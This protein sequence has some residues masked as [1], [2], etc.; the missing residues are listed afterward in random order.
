MGQLDIG[1]GTVEGARKSIAKSVQS[2]VDL[3]A[4]PEAGGDAKPRRESLQLLAQSN[5]AGA[6]TETYTAVYAS[7][8][9]TTAAPLSRR[10]S[11]MLGMGGKSAA[12]TTTA[13][14]ASTVAS[15]GAQ[16]NQSSAGDA[17]PLAAYNSRH[18]K[19]DQAG[20]N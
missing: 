14:P 8:V 16:P 10:L 4:A 3:E 18:S 17:D 15:A 2:E 6:F 13:T 11:K 19:Q 9:K 5:K 12:E 20:H 1:A 7:E